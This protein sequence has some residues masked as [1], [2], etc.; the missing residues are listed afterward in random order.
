MCIFGGGG[1][2]GQLVTLMPTS[3][4]PITAITGGAS[5][6]KKKEDQQQQAVAQS[7]ANNAATSV[8]TSN[9]QGST[10]LGM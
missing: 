2:L 7:A 6:S 9:D 4:N 3:A 8:L 1:G 10:L 5:S